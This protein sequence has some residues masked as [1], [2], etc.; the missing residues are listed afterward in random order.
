MGTQYQEVPK[1]LGLYK[2][3]SKSVNGSVLHYVGRTFKPCTRVKISWQFVI[4]DLDI[5]SQY[6][7]VAYTWLNLFVSPA[8]LWRRTSQTSRCWEPDNPIIGYKP[9]IR[10]SI[11]IS[12]SIKPQVDAKFWRI[13]FTFCIIMCRNIWVTNYVRF[14]LHGGP[15]VNSGTFLSFA[16]FVKIKKILVYCF[17]H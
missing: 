6:L 4:P 8:D 14:S 17:I 15:R 9:Q 1:H 10:Y 13:S 5:S 7:L 3:V 16:H 2:W 12:V 11:R